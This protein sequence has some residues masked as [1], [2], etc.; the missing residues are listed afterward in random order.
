ME[1]FVQMG[2]KMRMEGV[3]VIEGPGGVAVTSGAWQLEGP[4]GKV[5]MHGESVEVFRKGKEGW[6]AVVDCPFGVG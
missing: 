5:I 6:R 1:R 2:G 4:D 3:G